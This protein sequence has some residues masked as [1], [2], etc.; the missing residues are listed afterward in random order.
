MF[1]FIEREQ[2]HRHEAGLAFGDDVDREFRAD[3]IVGEDVCPLRVGAEARFDLIEHAKR[4]GEGFE[5]GVVRRVAVE[6]PEFGDVGVDARS[7]DGGG[8]ADAG[9]GEM[10]VMRGLPQRGNFHGVGEPVPRAV[11]LAQRIEERVV[12]DT[13]LRR[14]G[15]GD[16]RGVAGIGDGGQHAG[17]AF[18]VGAVG[19]E[20]A[21]VGR[22]DAICI[23]LSYIFRLQ[24]VDRNHENGLGGQRGSCAQDG[25]PGKQD[26]K[27]CA[28][29]HDQKE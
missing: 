7:V 17:D 10:R 24:A 23:R 1:D 19:D 11:V 18:R 21:E 29:F 9:G 13:V 27:A 5:H 22:V 6:S 25:E 2:V 26:V 28:T 16:E 20:G 12:E 4:A 15:S 14:P 3:L 8:P